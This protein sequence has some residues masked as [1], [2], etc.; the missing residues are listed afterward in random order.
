MRRGGIRVLEVDWHEFG[1]P[2]VLWNKI[3]TMVGSEDSWFEQ[4]SF[5]FAK[6]PRVPIMPNT[7]EENEDQ[8][9]IN[10]N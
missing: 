6:Q 3:L 5:A 1:P 2:V 4:L 10:E 9:D 8:G 7:G